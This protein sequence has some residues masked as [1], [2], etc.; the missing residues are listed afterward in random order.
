MQK[1]HRKR[2]QPV[3][4]PPLPKEYCHRREI[5]TDPFDFELLEK[6]GQGNDNEEEEDDKDKDKD[7]KE[8]AR[9]KSNKEIF[10]I[11][12]AA[13]VLGIAPLLHLGCAKIATEIKKLDQ[14]E[15]NRIIEE[16]EAYRRE[17]PEEGG[18]EEEA[19]ETLGWF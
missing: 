14:S 9:N 17:H 6:C 3:L 15:I 10:E 4:S 18:E 11:I 13:N 1:K 16:E 12:L 7:P 2:W 5:V 19:N 8:K